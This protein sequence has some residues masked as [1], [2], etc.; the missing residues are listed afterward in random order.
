MSVESSRKSVFRLES[1]RNFS[2][3]AIKNREYTGKLHLVNQYS[4]GFLPSRQ[5]LTHCTAS[6]MN[7][8]TLNGRKKFSRSHGG[9]TIRKSIS[10]LPKVLNINICKGMCHAAIN[11]PFL[12]TE[13]MSYYSMDFHRKDLGVINLLKQRPPY[14]SH[15]VTGKTQL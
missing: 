14:Q 7:D 6:E 1:N 9:P 15:I 8:T 4:K 13:N 5:D 12:P 10:F 2:K 11:S 3:L